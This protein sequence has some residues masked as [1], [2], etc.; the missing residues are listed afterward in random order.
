LDKANHLEGKYII[1][2]DLDRSP[3]LSHDRESNA[4]QLPQFFGIK[5]KICQLFRLMTF[6]VHRFSPKYASCKFH[7]FTM[8]LFN[9]KCKQKPQIGSFCT[10]MSPYLPNGGSLNQHMKNGGLMG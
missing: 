6:F 8:D 5:R 2:G 7:E 9:L 10:M 1:P 4:A 3:W